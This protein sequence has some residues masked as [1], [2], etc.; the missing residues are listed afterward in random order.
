M[1]AVSGLIERVRG[2]HNPSQ[3]QAIE[4]AMNQDRL[5]LL[6]GPPGTGKTK[7]IIGIVMA[8]LEATA[9]DSPE[10]RKRPRVFV[11][12]PSNA[13]ADEIALRIMHERG[14]GDVHDPKIGIPVV[15]I[16]DPRSVHEL[17]KPVHLEVLIEKKL[18]DTAKESVNVK[19]D[20]ELRRGQQEEHQK[21]NEDIGNIHVEREKLSGDR[22]APDFDKL[23][24]QLKR[25]HSRKDEVVNAMNASFGAA[26]RAHAMA[27]EMR[28]KAKLDILNCAQVLCCTLSASGSDALAEGVRG[29]DLIIIDEA[30]QATEISTL[31]PLKHLQTN[32]GRCVLVGDPCQL[33]ATVLSQAASSLR[34]ERSLFER[35][36]KCRFPVIMLDTQ[37]RMHPAIR[38][39]PSIHFY[40]NRL[41]DSPSVLSRKP[42]PYTARAQNGPCVFWDVRGD[43]TRRGMSWC[44][45]TEAQVVVR[46]ACILAPEQ[47]IHSFGGSSRY[48]R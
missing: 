12:A 35:L 34:Y 40:E 1:G 36:H 23:T 10:P 20:Q 33:P 2:Q 21:L 27:V 11:C 39:F 16:G 32:R 42:V 4:S 22:Q 46:A 47:S 17:V 24:V 44:N 14:S 3:W 37:Y 18:G 7:T 31:I 45:T 48:S 29:A 9:K 5:V 25:L 6:Q 19:G 8:F 38:R 28:L 43:E 30:A 41:R 13:A 15:R 26:R